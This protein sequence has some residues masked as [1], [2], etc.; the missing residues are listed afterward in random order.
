MR[1]IEKQH[2][3]TTIITND[4]GKNHKWMIS[5]NQILQQSLSH[6]GNQA[7]QEKLRKRYNNPDLVSNMC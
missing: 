3:T 7:G 4:S 5:L 1:E 6:S 2:L